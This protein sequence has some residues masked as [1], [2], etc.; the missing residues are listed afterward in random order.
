[1]TETFG[2]ALRRRRR[3]R[4][5]TQKDL[6]IRSGVDALT[7]SHY[8]NHRRYPD[9]PNLVALYRVLGGSIDRDTGLDSV[10]RRSG[11]ERR[12]GTDRRAE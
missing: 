4:A 10:E 11:Y 12:C 9:L 7:I 6:A 1:M 8:E 3:E 2:Q 5:W